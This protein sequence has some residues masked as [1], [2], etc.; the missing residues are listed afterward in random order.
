[1][2]GILF[3]WLIWMS[4]IAVHFFWP[5]S[6][7]RMWVSHFLLLLIIAN[8]FSLSIFSHQVNV[9]YVFLLFASM[10]IFSTLT[11]R[12]LCYF[13]IVLLS[14]IAFMTSLRLLLIYD[15]IIVII[16]PVWMLTI[17]SFFYMHMFVKQRQFRIPLF[18]AGMSLSEMI[19]H[20]FLAN[21]YGAR[22]FGDL[23][24]F[25]VVMATICLLYLWNTLEKFVI[26]FR[27]SVKKRTVSLGG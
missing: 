24:F 1:M 19:Y 27:E 5:K 22:M 8:N 14:F 10:F 2:D 3:Y 6:F 18:L 23:F 21:I 16:H 4:W 11:M 15:P 20:L 7:L 9:A 25:D 13:I 17:I 26:H 12:K